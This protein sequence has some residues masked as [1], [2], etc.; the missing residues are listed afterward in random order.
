[1]KGPRCT[2][3]LGKKNDRDAKKDG[4]C[5]K[6]SPFFFKRKHPPS[7]PFAKLIEVFDLHSGVFSEVPPLGGKVQH[8]LQDL[9]FA[10][11]CRSFDHLFGLCFDGCCRR[12]SRYASTIATVMLSSFRSPKNNLRLLID[13]R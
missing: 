13:K 8:A 2:F 4:R 9:K 3:S 5:I 7:R 12:S 1:M 6:N 11:G 10:I